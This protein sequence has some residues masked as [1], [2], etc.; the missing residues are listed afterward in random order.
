MA[1][2][3]LT[4]VG[5]TLLFAF[6]VIRVSRPPAPVPASAPPTS[7]SAERAMRHV[8]AIAQRPHP[9]GSVDHDRV[10]DYVIGELTA[11]GLAPQVQRATAVG[12]RYQ[13]AGRVENILARLPGREPGG[14]A[15]LLMAHYDGVEAGPAAADDGA[16]SAAILEAL[17]A[18]RAGTPL[19][20]DVIALFTDGEEAGLLGAAAF[21]REHPW[22][23]D[24]G[25]A[26]NFEAR[27]TSGRSFMFET[28]PRNLDV[29]RVLRAAPS[30]SA[31]SDFTTV[32]RAM[33]NDTDLS[34][35]ALLDVPALNFAFAD[36]VDRYHTTHDD[37][38]HLN[39]GSVQ[40]HGVQALALAR[41]FGDGPLPRPRT[42]D[43]IFFTFPGFG[44]IVYPERWALPLALLGAVLVVLFA[45]RVRR[46][47][48]R[49]GLGMSLGAIALIVSVVAAGALGYVVGTGLGRVH[50]A[51]PWGGAPAWSRIYWA[52]VAV[53]AF[54]V[55]A[56]FY[57]LVRR[58]AAPVSIHAGALIVVAA[59]SIA[60]AARA[61]G[62]S[63]LFAWPLIA[64]ALAALA[65]SGSTTASRTLAQ[66]I[67]GWVSAFVVVVFLV[68]LAFAISVV[69]LG[70][71]GT[72]GIVAIVLVSLIAWM[73]AP[74]LETLTAGTRWRTPVACT[75]A[76]LLLFAVGIFTV[77]QGGDHPLA[78]RVAYVADAD[79]SDAWLASSA[80]MARAS[81][82]TRGVVGAGGGAPPGGARAPRW[83]SSVV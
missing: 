48:P 68:P 4:A 3:L 55:A 70:V 21:V 58:G 6:A 47:E 13:E 44:L 11:L 46:M 33:P 50:A 40:H 73:L 41:A 63:Y 18:L 53:L 31:G 45:V 78:S 79:G 72:G 17:R 83:G 54:A 19:A 43:G 71:T 39:P 7:F 59:I 57:V 69:M 82:W 37:I 15:V 80:S 9:M 36:G 30:V 51:V 60:V 49:S 1:A 2:R 25:V 62:L 74:H 14:Q 24:V 16:G 38:A 56:A 75:I 34:E 61:P 12:T 29:A 52:G 28:G 27:G 32:Y 67:A 10:R 35:L 5:L 8:R 66:S 65:S 81:A 20:H 22:A 77:K 23:K 42:G 64:A 26:L 76:A